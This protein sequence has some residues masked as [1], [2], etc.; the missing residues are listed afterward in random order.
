MRFERIADSAAAGDGGSLA[1][2]FECVGGGRASAILDRSIKSRGTP[3]YGCVTLDRVPLS[4]DSAS[5]L[6]IELHRLHAVLAPEERA[7]HTVLPFIEA[8]CKQSA[9]Q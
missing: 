5:E 4:P 1:L 2:I 8:L 9:A 6:L 3:A 7:R